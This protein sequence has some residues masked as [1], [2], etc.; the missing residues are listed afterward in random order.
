MK[1]KGNREPEILT[2]AANK[3][4]PA[5]M[6]AFLAV[7]EETGRLTEAARIA[8]VSRQTHYNRVATDAAYRKA[9]EEA[10]ERAAQTLEDEAVRRAVT[11]VRQPV[12]YQGKLVKL[13]RRTLYVTTYSDMLLLALL[14]R[15]RP[16]LYRDQAVTEHT[17][18][19]DIDI[20][21]RM[22]AARKRLAETRAAAG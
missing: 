6:R 10:E 12:M 19:V 11:G 18:P 1:R 20:V 2:G 3:R 21:S 9:F 16:H 17:G 15:F 4:T 7:Y 14:K 22:Q 5:R 13:G 8:G